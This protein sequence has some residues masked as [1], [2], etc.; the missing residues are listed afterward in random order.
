MLKGQQ[1]VVTELLPEEMLPRKRESTQRTVQHDPV[2]FQEKRR[3]EG[4]QQNSWL[5]AENSQLNV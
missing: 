2:A 5:V 3:E 1:R 4:K